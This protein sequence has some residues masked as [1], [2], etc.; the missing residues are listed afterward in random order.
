[1]HLDSFPTLN[2]VTLLATGDE[3]SPGSWRRLEMFL[4]Q[5][6][7]ETPV[8]VR[9]HGFWMLVTGALILTALA[10]WVVDDPQ[11]IAHGLERILKP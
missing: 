10:L 3:Q 2:S 7:R 5:S 1:M 9:P 6:L 8:A 4:R 11:T